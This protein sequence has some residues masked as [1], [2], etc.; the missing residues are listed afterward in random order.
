MPYGKIVPVVAYI[1]KNY[2]LE[3][4]KKMNKVYFK[5]LIGTLK[6][7]NDKSHSPFHDVKLYFVDLLNSPDDINTGVLSP[8]I[9]L[10]LIMLGG[11]P[12]ANKLE[13]HNKVL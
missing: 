11:T 2:N 4:V 10:S 7:I 12:I 6:K 8:N 1:S 9:F 13:V 5:T 3:V